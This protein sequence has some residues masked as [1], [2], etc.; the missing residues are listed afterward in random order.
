[1]KDTKETL[2]DRW[3]P[4]RY[5][6][7]VASRGIHMRLLLVAALLAP[8]STAYGAPI[9]EGGVP[10]SIDGDG[11]PVE[12]PYILDAGIDP[13]LPAGLSIAGQD[14]NRIK[15]FP[16]GVVV[17]AGIS[18]DPADPQPIEALPTDAL[19]APFWAMLAPAH[20][21]AGP[22]GEVAAIAGA[23]SLTLVWRNLPLVG[24][25]AGGQT[26]SFS[27]ELAW[28]AA[29]VVRRVELR[30]GALPSESLTTEPR[31][32][33]L[34]HSRDGDDTVLELL[35]DP[36]GGQLRGRA[37]AL[38]EGSSDGESGV[39]IIELSDDGQIVG[40]MEHVL[41]G[42]DG[43]LEPPDGVRGV[44]NCPHRFNPLQ[45]DLDGD[46][47]GD[48]CDPDDDED[49]LDDLID[50][51]PRHANRDQSDV[52]G[53][54]AGD[55]CDTDDDGDG[56]PDDIDLCPHHANLGNGDLDRDGI[57]DVC[58]PDPDGDDPWAAAFR[59][60][61]PD[62]CPLS[63]DPG[64]WDRDGDLI[65]DACDLRPDVQCA[66][67]C[68]AQR[69]LDNDRVGDMHDLCPSVYDPAQ[70]D[71]DGDGRGDACDPDRDGNGVLDAEQICPWPGCLPLELP[72]PLPS[73][74]GGWAP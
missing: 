5:G 1:M 8:L 65:G 54:G 47:L 40:D 46:E 64:R 70:G 12:A 71:L 51:C 69:D 44:D 33:L 32:G 2:L 13:G 16:Q 60:F 18:P 74:F 29:A 30:Y 73:G 68:G 3:P 35:P 4:P 7:A 11:Q 19:I 31:A 48:A 36:P 23:D 49:L 55:A 66:G 22:I 56:W 59:R 10:V 17:L 43:E 42:D 63:F 26:A 21:G 62:T 41:A 72:E 27:V 45:E 9:A 52:D 14:V 20:C 37:K 24:C 50:N 39:W 57:G 58:D 67:D 6:R 25:P 15:V 61:L 34:L 28:D 53:D 38:A